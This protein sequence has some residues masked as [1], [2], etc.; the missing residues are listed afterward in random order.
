MNSSD[1]KTRILLDTTY[2]LPILGVEVKEAN[3]TLKKVRTLH[4]EG[5]I[6]LYYSPFSLLEALGKIAKSPF[7]EE[8]IRN[9]LTSIT[10]SRVF[11]EIL[12]TASG[13]LEALKLRSKG[14]TDLIDLLLYQTAATNHLKWLTKDQKILSFIKKMGK[15]QKPILQEKEF[16]QPPP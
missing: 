11:T 13:Y 1:D 10:K 3:H 2:L 6:K 12:P 16:N 7:D 14:F 8:R 5:R 15:N 9:G 4:L